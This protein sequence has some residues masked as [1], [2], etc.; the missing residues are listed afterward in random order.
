MTGLR[1]KPIELS[2]TLPWVG[3]FARLV[4]G[5]VFAVAGALK[6]AQPEGSVQA[7]A[8]YDLLPSGL[9]RPV[10]YG[11][12]FLEIAIA[13]LLLLGLTT[14]MAA[15]LSLLLLAVFIGGVASAWARGLSID[16]GCFGGGG[17]VARGA[18]HYL[19]E[20]VRDVLLAVLAVLLVSHPRTRLALY[21][22]QIDDY[23]DE[24][25]RV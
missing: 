14:R 12:P 20:I 3:T 23:Q 9:V 10:G 18:T 1:V 25:A 16:C 4:L 22:A 8:A 2:R 19:Q 6:V 5:G 13:L 17:Q 7:V 24:E 21:G 11:L 15:V